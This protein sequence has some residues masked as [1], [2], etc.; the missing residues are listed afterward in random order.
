MIQLAVVLTSIQLATNSLVNKLPLPPAVLRPTW[1]RM[2]LTE[3]ARMC[4]ALQKDHMGDNAYLYYSA[5]LMNSEQFCVEIEAL[6]D[7][8][9]ELVGESNVSL[10]LKS[11]H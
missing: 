3:Q 4:P 10:W 11:D 2:R 5:Y 8:I 6:L 9:K 1:A 7:C